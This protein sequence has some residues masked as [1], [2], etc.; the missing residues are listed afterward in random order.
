MFVDVVVVVVVVSTMIYTGL[1]N[2]AEKNGWVTLA[3]LFFAERV[4]SRIQI[5]LVGLR[6]GGRRFIVCYDFL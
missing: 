5:R 4:H 3:A 6:K 2:N 1:I